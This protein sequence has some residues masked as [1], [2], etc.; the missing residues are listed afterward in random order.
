MPDGNPQ[1][2][3]SAGRN[4]AD[5]LNAPEEPESSL[6]KFVMADNNIRQA[7]NSVG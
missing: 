1:V 2:L 7:K 6:R 3:L 4:L 5:K